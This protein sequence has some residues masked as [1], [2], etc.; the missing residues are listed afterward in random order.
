MESVSMEGEYQ[1]G[2]SPLTR[3]GSLNVST[4]RIPRS[5]RGKGNARL[6]VPRTRVY[7]YAPTPEGEALAAEGVCTVLVHKP[8][9]PSVTVLA[10]S[11]HAERTREASTTREH[12]EAIIPEALRYGLDS[13]H[14]GA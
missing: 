14:E 6:Y 2:L 1:G 11:F 10:S 3:Y 5:K 12:S 4:A 8:G 7:G 13:I 9:Q